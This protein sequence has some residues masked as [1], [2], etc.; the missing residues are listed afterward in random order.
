MT[1]VPGDPLED[2]GRDRG[3]EDDSAAHGEQVHTAALGERPSVVEHDRL[4]EPVLDRLLLGQH[5]VEILAAPL[6]GGDEAGVRDPAPTGDHRRD[7]LLDPFLPEI[8]AQV[9]GGHEG[10]DRKRRRID[11]KRACS[12]E[13]QRADVGRLQLVDPEQLETCLIQLV[14]RPLH[15]DG[16]GTCRGVHPDHVIVETEYGGALRGLVGADPFEDT[17]AVVERV[18][19][20]VDVRVVPVDELAVHPYLGCRFHDQRLT[21]VALGEISNREMRPDLT[22]PR[23]HRVVASLLRLRADP[24]PGPWVRRRVGD[25]GVALRPFALAGNRQH[26]RLDG[27]IG[28]HGAGDT[29]RD[30][31]D[32]VARCR[33]RRRE[34]DR[35]R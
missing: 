23:M 35:D 21:N 15:R 28:G 4:V 20:E 33:G 17:R 1:R 10:V 31:V 16:V 30:L 19:E 32:A 5:R 8:T 12:V 6:G 13:G 24:A 34:L 22:S 7:P 14:H 26:P 25:G 2:P 11:A 29:G 27:P 9:E 3:R 18:G